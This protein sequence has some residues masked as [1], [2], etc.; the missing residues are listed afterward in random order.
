MIKIEELV[1]RL[2]N[3]AKQKAE[4]RRVAQYGPGGG[5]PAAKAEQH[6][7]WDAAVTLR[8]QEERIERLK[9]QHNICHHSIID[10]S[11]QRDKFQADS[12]SLLKVLKAGEKVIGTLDLSCHRPGEAL[13]ELYTAITDY[14]KQLKVD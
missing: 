7:E 3:Q 14:N 13:K 2:E 4:D 6:I 1:V 5:E 9:R 12:T 8:E 11:A 10:I